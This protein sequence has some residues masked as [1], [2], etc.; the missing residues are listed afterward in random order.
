MEEFFPGDSDLFWIFHAEPAV[1]V[2]ASFLRKAKRGGQSGCERHPVDSCFGYWAVSD[3][4]W[5]LS[6]GTADVSEIS[7]HFSDGYGSDPG[8]IV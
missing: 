2:Y 6:A 8:R 7:G 4:A 1:F 5:D 3:P